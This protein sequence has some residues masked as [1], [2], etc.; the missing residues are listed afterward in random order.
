MLRLRMAGILLPFPTESIQRLLDKDSMR[1]FLR[2][3]LRKRQN[4]YK[5]GGGKPTV[6][7]PSAAL[8]VYRKSV[9]EARRPDGFTQFVANTAVYNYLKGQSHLP[10]VVRP[11]SYLFVSDRMTVRKFITGPT[12]RE[13]WETLSGQTTFWE[14]KVYTPEDVERF[15]GKHGITKRMIEGMDKTL[16]T[17]LVRGQKTNFGVNPKIPIELDL[18]FGNMFILGRT[19]HTNEPIISVI[20]QGLHTAKGVPG[21]I[22]KGEVF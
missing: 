4:L 19:T 14:S 3:N 8:K 9:S 20:D 10:F 22:V 6:Q 7:L 1:N 11:L 21:M 15:A 18:N 5:S 12:F 2:S 17:A 13:I 16:H